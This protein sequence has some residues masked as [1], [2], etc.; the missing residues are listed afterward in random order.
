M[1]E[2]SS[3]AFLWML[4]NGGSHIWL[5]FL[6]DFPGLSTSRLKTEE[7]K[8]VVYKELAILDLL[9]LFWEQLLQ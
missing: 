4:S 1:V 7:G 5:Q 9:E 6:T 2:Y 8:V 3:S